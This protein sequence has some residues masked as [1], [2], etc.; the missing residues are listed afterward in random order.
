[1]GAE[2]SEFHVDSLQAPSSQHLDSHSNKKGPFNTR[3]TQR[4]KSPR[5]KGPQLYMNYRTY[6][7]QSN[8]I[9]LVSNYRKLM[10]RG[11]QGVEFPKID[12]IS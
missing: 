7:L 5:T 3:I 6:Q 11:N 9:I 1:M 10:A 8:C 12:V 2:C 4:Y